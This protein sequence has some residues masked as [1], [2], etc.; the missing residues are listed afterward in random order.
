MSTSLA[1]LTGLPLS[2]DS[3]RANSS[4]LSLIISEI[5]INIPERLSFGIVD[6]PSK[7][8]LAA[9]TA[10]STSEESESGMRLYASPVEGLMLSK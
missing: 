5:R 1:R 9:D 4:I 7:A 6:Q 3:A 10:I 2:I 8:A